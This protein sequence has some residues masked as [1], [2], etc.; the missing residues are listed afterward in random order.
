MKVQVPYSQKNSLKVDNSKINQI[1]EGT[2]EKIEDLNKTENVLNDILSLFEYVKV[3][4]GRN[5]N[6]YKS[7]VY[8]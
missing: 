7:G 6:A 4:S 3:N 5:L 8:G 2:T 1:K